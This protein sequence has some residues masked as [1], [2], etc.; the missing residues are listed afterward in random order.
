[1][2]NTVTRS[3]VLKQASQTVAANAAKQV[4]QAVDSKSTAQATNN[5][6]I[7]HQMNS[8][9]TGYADDLRPEQLGRA[10]PVENRVGPRE[11]SL[12]SYF[13]G[14]DPLE[15][16]R[17][18]MRYKREAE[19]FDAKQG[20]SCQAACKSDA[21]GGPQQQQQQQCSCSAMTRYNSGSVAT[22]DQEALES[23]RLSQKQESQFLYKQMQNSKIQSASQRNGSL[24]DGAQKTTRGADS[25]ARRPVAAVEV[26]RAVQR[27]ANEK[28]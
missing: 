17:E 1:M 18:E 7:Q 20:V 25:V 14:R 13:T 23:V 2:G 16:A 26:E 9:H 24:Y 5:A 21:W 19:Q 27:E 15:R 12:P 22:I 3:A 8:N 6:S 4:Q 10:P 28:K 11:K